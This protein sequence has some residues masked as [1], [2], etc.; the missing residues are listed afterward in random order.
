ARARINAEL[1]DDSAERT[2]LLRDLGEMRDLITDLLESERLADVQAGG[3][4]ALQTEMSALPDIVHEQCD[5]QAAAG[6]VVLRLDDTLP[7]LPLDR[8]RMR[9]LLR[10]LVDNALRHGSEPG[11]PPIVSTSGTP[12][13]VQLTVRDFGPGMEEG[14]L[15]HAAEAF[16]RADAARLRSTG[17]VG[18]GLYLCK[19]VAEAHG[20][21]LALRN[22]QPGLEI[23]VML[24][25]SAAQ[26]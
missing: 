23:T 7:A 25:V 19:L 1:I 11:Q 2:A 14:Q 21:T 4:A 18:L 15:Q 20:G 16:Y 10:N 9:L 5:A 6:S 24:P 17:G 3:H 26:G 8:A 22:A 13:S 12:Q